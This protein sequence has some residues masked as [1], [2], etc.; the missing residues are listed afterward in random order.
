M[1]GPGTDPGRLALV[2][3]KCAVCDPTKTTQDPVIEP[4]AEP[5]D[6][7]SMS[8]TGKTLGGRYCIEG[9]LGEGERR[10]RSSPKKS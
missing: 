9:R 7:L 4:A 8:L 1:A 3:L 10:P 2:E 5:V 6:P